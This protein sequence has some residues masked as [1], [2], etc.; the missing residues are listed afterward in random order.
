MSRNTRFLDACKGRKSDCM[1]IWL[2]RQAGRYQPSYRELR[3]RV[4][5]F[6]LCQTP[7]LAAQV[8]VTAVE[9]LNADAAIIFSD[10]LVPLMPMGADVQM[11][12]R[13]PQLEPIRTKADIDK[14]RV[15]D[16]A[17][18]IGYVMEAIAKVNDA[19]DGAVPQ[20]GFAGAP[21]TLA[22][23]LVEGGSS[24]SFPHLKK[25][26]FGEPDTARLLLDKLATVVA[27]HLRAQV[28]AGC[29]AIQLFDTWAG[30][31][32]AQDYRAHVA[33]HI[34]RIFEELADLDVPR[35]FFATNTS[36]LLSI[37]KE[38]GPDVI[39]VD[40]TANLKDVKDLVGRPLQGNLDPCCLFMDEAGLEARI[41]AVLEQ[42]G[43]APHVFN[44]GHGILPQTDPARARFLV[45]TVHRLTE[46]A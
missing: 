38:C 2:M 24:R 37:I 43:D 8:T 39:G 17:R 15:I 40:W 34:K 44:L 4:S 12:E 25:L 6:E 10:I 3:K 1:P 27:R 28:E 11:T 45:D 29:H 21:L 16:P 20:I 14:L 31:L 22:S 35:I 13:G 46:A 30:I 26:L 41:K 32:S 36:H 33:P 5:F 42:V 7:E 23:Y 19:L 18:E 9:E